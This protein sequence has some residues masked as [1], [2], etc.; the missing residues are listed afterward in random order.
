M[1]V[2]DAFWSDC[3]GVP[4]NY[5]TR[6]N[7]QVKE[8]LFGILKDKLLVTSFPEPVTLG[9]SAKG[10]IGI[11]N[12]NVGG[13]KTCFSTEIKCI[14]PFLSN[15]SCDGSGDNGVVVG[16]YDASKKVFV[17]QSDPNHNWFTFQPSYDIRAADRVVFDALIN[18]Q[19]VSPDHY[20]MELNVYR[21]PDFLSCVAIGNPPDFGDSRTALYAN[22][23]FILTVA[24]Q[25]R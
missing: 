21:Q 2:N 10:Y 25:L 9:R 14:R 6:S 22:K 3:I 4:T 12:A 1:G 17:S 19:G 16:G 5:Q 20:V 18:V 24:S 8:A 7:D 23:S 11:R 15:S 13:G